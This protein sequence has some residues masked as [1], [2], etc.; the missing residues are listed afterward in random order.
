MTGVPALQELIKDDCAAE[1]KTEH[2][3]SMK[4]T[5]MN[6]FVMHELDGKETADATGEV[7]DEGDCERFGRALAKT[8]ED[9]GDM[10]DEGARLLTQA[11][12]I[13]FRQCRF[14]C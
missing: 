11:Y 10:F 12:A 1:R 6:D 13:E 7:F 2:I 4:K 14:W 3:Q 8:R 9:V 5:L